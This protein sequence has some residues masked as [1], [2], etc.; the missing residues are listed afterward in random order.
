MESKDHRRFVVSV[1]LAV[2]SFGQIMSSSSTVAGKTEAAFVYFW[3]LQRV[4]EASRL[5]R[6]LIYAQ[7]SVV[8]LNPAL[9][10]S[11]SNIITW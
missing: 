5:F 10:I 3:S 8:E 9:F 6:Y 2:L 7:S 4:A 11:K 1:L